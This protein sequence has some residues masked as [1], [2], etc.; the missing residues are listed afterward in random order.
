MQRI[1]NDNFSTNCPIF[2][3]EH[4]QRLLQILGRLSSWKI[5]LQRELSM[6][7]ELEYGLVVY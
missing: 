6:K 2:R 7:F 5:I 4:Q 1:G 3:Q